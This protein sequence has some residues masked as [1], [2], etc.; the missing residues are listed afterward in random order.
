MIVK[1]IQG[2]SKDIESHPAYF[3]LSYP[4]GNHKKEKVVLTRLRLGTSLQNHAFNVKS[5]VFRYDC[6]NLKLFD[7]DIHQIR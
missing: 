6:S 1:Q 5:R 7:H 3:I 4:L 2:T